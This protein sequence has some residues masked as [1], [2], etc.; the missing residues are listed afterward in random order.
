MNMS[1]SANNITRSAALNNVGITVPGSESSQ[2]FVSGTWF[3]TETTS[4]VIILQLRGRMAGKVVKTAVT[5]KSK[6]KC[7]TCGTVNKSNMK[8][9]GK[10]GTALQII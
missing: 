8:F 3:K 1:S 2:K 4:H 6:A 5:V 7:S 9:C 10:C